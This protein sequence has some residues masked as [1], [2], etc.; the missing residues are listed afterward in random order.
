MTKKTLIIHELIHSLGGVSGGVDL[1]SFVGN[2]NLE[3]FPDQE[4]T[5]DKIVGNLRDCKTPI[6][7]KKVI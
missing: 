4:N 7:F 5:T 6:K 1:S 3:G 2:T